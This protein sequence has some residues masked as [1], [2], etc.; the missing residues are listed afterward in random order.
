MNGRM[1]TN[2]VALP[3]ERLAAHAAAAKPAPAIVHGRAVWRLARALLQVVGGLLTVQLV[4]PWLGSRARERLVGRWSRQMLCA[5]GVHVEHQ[6]CLDDGARL[7][8]ANHISWLDVMA[9]HAFC[10][11]ARFV[12]MAELQRW[13]VVARLVAAAGT[14][15]LQRERKR[16]L[17][18]VVRE[19][20][21]ALRKGAHVA[22]FPEGVVS[23][24][25]GLQHF[26]GNLLQSAIDA[27]VTV[28]PVALRYADTAGPVSDAVLFTG[29][30]TLM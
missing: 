25:R 9:L 29:G 3:C 21:A 8:V 15:Y 26:H 2:A 7:L 1:R 18:R 27:G 28:Q 24:G 4:F 19:V 20:T 14:I 10:G 12:A 17:L 11:R 30:V 13:T 5:L 23:D 16:D 6:G 22:V